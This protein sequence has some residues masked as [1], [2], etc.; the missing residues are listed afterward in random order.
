[1]SC[2]IRQTGIRRLTEFY[3]GGP[4]RI[5]AVDVPG[6]GKDRIQRGATENW[7]GIANGEMNFDFKVCAF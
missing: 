5:M 3:P 7:A 4:E 6:K 1:M 2:F